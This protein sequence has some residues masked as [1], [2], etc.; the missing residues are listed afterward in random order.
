MACDPTLK[1]VGMRLVHEP[2]AAYQMM[3]NGLWDIPR[4]IACLPAT[5][6][7]I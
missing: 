3:P 6:A 1:E 5:R 7:N 4:C 2:P